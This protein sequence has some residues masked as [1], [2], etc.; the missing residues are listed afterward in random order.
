MVLA[1]VFAGCK[2]KAAPPA[3]GSGSAPVAVVGSGSGSAVPDVVAKGPAFDV[4]RVEPPAAPVPLD[5]K[6]RV[7]VQI[8]AQGALSV[9]KLVE[10]PTDRVR[11]PVAPDGDL[12]AAVE[13]LLGKRAGP[14]AP[15]GRY[16]DLLADEAAPA[17]RA[18]V[19]KS[20]PLD[21][22]MPIV[23]ASPKAPAAAVA[24]ALAKAGGVLGV[25]ADGKLA[26]LRGFARHGDRGN[27]LDARWLELHVRPDALHVVALPAGKLERVPWNKDTVDARGL[28]AAIDRLF[29]RQDA[30]EPQVDVLV[31]ATDTITAQ[32]LVDVIAA[33]VAGNVDTAIGVA[34]GAPDE[35]A[36][37]VAAANVK[38]TRIP[39]VPT[40]T[41]PGDISRVEIRRS[42]Q[43][44]RQDYAR[45]Y[46]DELK[47][48]PQLAGKVTVSFTIGPNGKVTRATGTGMTPA[49]NECVAKVFTRMQFPKPTDGG[50]VNVNYPV[51]FRPESEAVEPRSRHVDRR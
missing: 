22:G 26:A 1:V 44:A 24:G 48:D 16:A 40:D 34:P 4:P 31:G 9:V 25:L 30:V 21:A 6:D 15:P 46:K 45:C 12:A 5:A 36:A 32:Q 20:A 13:E 18:D 19:A 28:L 38:A 29:E 33:L 43:L 8:D 3:A 42:I 27:S 35:R 11:R 7:V 10:P 39:K 51:I 37:Q 41:P 2:D 14:A 47:K 50:V 23:L 49:M 17:G